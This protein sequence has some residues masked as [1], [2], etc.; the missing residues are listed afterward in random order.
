MKIACVVVLTSRFLAE[1]QG[2]Q[3]TSLFILLLPQTTLRALR[4]GENK[5]V[6][7]S[8]RGAGSAEK[9]NVYFV[10]TKNTSANSAPLR[11]YIYFFLAK[12]PRSPRTSIPILFLYE[13]PLRT[14][15]LGES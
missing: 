11:D 5:I 13:I 15:R 2:S 12:A 10:L 7:F 6:L 8:R 14:L 4:P 3:R 1:A 9:T